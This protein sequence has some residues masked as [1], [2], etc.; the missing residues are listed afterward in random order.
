M[1][2]LSMSRSVTFNTFLNKFVLTGSAVKFDPAQSRN[3]YGFYYSTSDDFVHWSMRQLIIE[4]PSLFSHQCGGPDALSYPSLIDHG[5]T[6]R[7]FRVTD[8]T[9]YLYYTVMHYNAACQLTLDRDLAR[10]P[11]QFSP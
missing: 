1:R 9:V 8:A 7:N 4:V 5:S 11:I 2:T 3:V 10:V 6:E